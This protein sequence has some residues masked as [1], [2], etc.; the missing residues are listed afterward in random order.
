[1]SRNYVIPTVT[2]FH[3]VE[4]KIIRRAIARAREK[5]REAQ[6]NKTRWRG[7]QAQGGA[8]MANSPSLRR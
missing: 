2:V 6:S 1:M 7:S 3:D 8:C 5:A 4:R